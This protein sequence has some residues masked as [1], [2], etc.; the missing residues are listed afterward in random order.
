MLKIKH[1][2]NKNQGKQYKFS[3]HCKSIKALFFF[4]FKITG[5]DAKEKKRLTE[6]QVL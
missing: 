1:P 6:I 2:V 5:D 3:V 4:F